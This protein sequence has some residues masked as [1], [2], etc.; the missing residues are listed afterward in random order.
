MKTQNPVICGECG[1][2]N[3]PGDR[4]CA[5][6]GA[7]LEWLKAEQPAAPI[8][9]V[10]TAPVQPT[11]DGQPAETTK[12]TEPVAGRPEPAAPEAAQPGVPEPGQPVPVPESAAPEPPVQ[13][14]LGYAPVPDRPGAQ[15]DPSLRTG[16]GAVEPAGP[17]AVRPGKRKLK[18]PRAKPRPRPA[19]SLPGDLICGQCG[20]GNSPNRKFCRQCAHSLLDAPKVAPLPWW[21]RL[22]GARARKPARAGTRPKFRQHRFPTRTVTTVLILG[23]LGG[24][25]FAAREQLRSGFG[26]VQDKFSNNS[27]LRPSSIEA[28]SSAEGHPP[29]LAIDGVVNRAWQPAQPGDGV[30]E[31]LQAHYQLPVRLVFLQIRTGAAEQ[32]EQFLGSGRPLG[33]RVE[34]SLAGG[35]PRTLDLDLADK[36]TV[37]QFYL[38]QDEVVGVKLTVRSS[39]PGTSDP[40]IALSEVEFLGRSGSDPIRSGRIGSERGAQALPAKLSG[41]PSASRTRA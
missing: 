5:E 18:A 3:A 1:A 35:A 23:L 6:C 41:T 27:P 22:F 21:H 2:E 16:P 39:I 33:L 30:G 4:F 15:V 24:G 31:F 37:Q 19:G 12:A 38:G 14:A 13:P 10:P 29:E 40:R 9:P 17:V 32:S 26:F 7:Y 20:T 8:A 34:L 36:P 28:S 11:M 25:G